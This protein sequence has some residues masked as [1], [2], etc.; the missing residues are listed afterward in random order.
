MVAQSSSRRWTHFHSALQL[1]IQRSAH[2]WTFEDFTECF[3]LYVDEEK[4]GSSA[5]FNAISGHMESQIHRDLNEVLSKYDAQANIDLLHAIVNEAK[6]RKLDPDQRLDV[7]QEDLEP[8][9][10]VCA[11][12]IPVLEAEAKRLR[13]LIA[14]EHEKNL[15]LQQQLQQSEHEVDSQN[16]STRSLLD[17]VDKIQAAS[18]NVPLEDIE[19]WAIQTAES[20]KSSL[21]IA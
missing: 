6:A 5:V 15:Q 3:P 2:K 11:R 1:A 7:W 12:T 13:Q 21:P 9:S 16:E 4:N 19:A 18:D 20:T 17:K 8:H 14:E 10:A